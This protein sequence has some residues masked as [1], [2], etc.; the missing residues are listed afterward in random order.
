MKTTNILCFLFLVTF[1]VNAQRIKQGTFE[2]PMKEFLK[3]TY[4][5]QDQDLLIINFRY[6]Q[7][8]CHYD[9]YRD[10]PRSVNFFNDLY[11]KIDTQAAR[12]IYVYAEESRAKRII[13]GVDHFPDIDKRLRKTVFKPYGY[14]YGLLVLNQNGAYRVVLGEYSENDITKCIE[15]LSL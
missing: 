4:N 11:R 15:Q 6:P 13:D 8:S 12:N 7:N 2:D 3:K 9:Q 5:W 10:L 14:C 1:S